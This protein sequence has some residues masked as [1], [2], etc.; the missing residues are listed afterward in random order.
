MGH[1]SYEIDADYLGV[2]GRINVEEVEKSRLLQPRRV[3]ACGAMQFG[4]KARSAARVPAAQ[5]VPPP[6][7]TVLFLGGFEWLP[8]YPWAPSDLRRM[9]QDIHRMCCEY[10]KILRVRPHPRNPSRFLVPYVDWLRKQHPDTVVVSDE[11]SI[12]RD[13]DSTEFV[14]ASGFDGAVLDALLDRRL[15]I[16][17]VPEGVKPGIGNKPFEAMAA[18]AYGYEALEEL[19]STVVGNPSRVAALRRAQDRFLRNYIAES[20]R[21]PWDG[22]LDLITEALRES[23][24]IRL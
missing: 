20:D 5:N 15:V 16:C 14:M 10:G 21:D 13:F 11:P 17:Y 12:Q 19:F 18:M 3:I 7:K 4:D 9:L 22:A 1:C 2:F 24:S 23:N 8:F 6:K